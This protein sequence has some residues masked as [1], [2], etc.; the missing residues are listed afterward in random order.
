VTFG[1]SFEH[2][3]NPGETMAKMYVSYT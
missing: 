1:L 2:I 3:A